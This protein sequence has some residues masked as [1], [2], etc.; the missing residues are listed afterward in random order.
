MAGFVF[1]VNQLAIGHDVKNATATFD[2][3]DFKSV[4]FLNCGRQTGGLRG[5]VSL[6][7]V[8]DGNLHEEKW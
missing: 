3:F 1:A 4:G 7:A 5:V 6:N 2:E 8:G